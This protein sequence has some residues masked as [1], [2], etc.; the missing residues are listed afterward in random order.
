MNMELPLGPV[1]TDVA[2]LI[3]SDDDI[4]RLQH[5][6]V[7]GVIL[8]ARNFESPA[9]L[10]QLTASI[11]A[12]RNPVLPIAVDHEGGRVQRF[13][14]GFTAIPPM[15]ALGERWDKLPADAL[16]IAESVGYVIGA[17]LIAHGVDFS[18]TPVLD[19][20]WGESGVIGDR[21][22]H[23]R[24]EVISQLARAVMSGLASTGMISV[25]KHFP[26]HGYVRADSHHEIP[27]DERQLE[28]I[29]NADMVPFRD[30]AEGI[31][32][33]VMPAHVI[34]PAVDDQPAGFSA[35][36]LKGILRG[37]MG[38]DGLI[39]SD[40]LSMEGASVAGNIT[41]RARA[42]LNA[43][44]DMALIC[45]DPAKADEML[46]GLSADGVMPMPELARRLQRIHALAKAG[47]VDASHYEAARNAIAALRID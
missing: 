45:N 40:D 10:K 29:W 13:R 3:L 35:T 4:R 7:G 31:M 14:D 38:F 30:L 9:Q 5:P 25:G 11:H 21:A 19:V 32:S 42:A 18:F 43:G 44:C 34:Y 47:K 15:R 36:W 22:F 37:R 23:P 26:G 2:G 33:A 24:P 27:V 41:E 17:E 46:A 20:D 39:F 16:R 8:F 1:M 12:L 28:D 6:L